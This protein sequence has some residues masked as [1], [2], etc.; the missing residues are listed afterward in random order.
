MEKIKKL[1]KTSLIVELCS[2]MNIFYHTFVRSFLS[3]FS[4]RVLNLF[5]KKWPLF[6]TVPFPFFKSLLFL[7]FCC[8]THL[9]APRTESCQ[10]LPKK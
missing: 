8:I 10:I 5:I 1:P 9:L 2:K 6:L 7:L 4:S 3:C